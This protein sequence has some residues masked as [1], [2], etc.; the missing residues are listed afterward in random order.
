M[1]H[2]ILRNIGIPARLGLFTAFLALALGVVLWVGWTG[3]ARLSAAIEAEGGN[4]SLVISCAMIERQVYQSWIA[5]KEA[6]TIYVESPDGVSDILMDYENALNTC[7]ALIQMLS[8]AEETPEE[9]A[10]LLE[11]T[12]T[13]FTAFADASGKM[14]EGLR[15]GD[16]QASSSLVAVLSYKALVGEVNKLFTRINKASGALVSESS[17]TAISARDFLTI[18]AA[19]LILISAAFSLLM[20]ASINKPLRSLVSA[21]ERIGRGDL[22]VVADHRGKDELARIAVSVNALAGDLRALVATVEEKLR[23]LADTGGT[24]AAN[25]EETGAAVVQINASIVNSRR[26]LDGQSSAVA[27]VTDSIKGFTLGFDKL[28][29]RIQ[30]LSANVSQSSASTEEMI[31]NIESVAANVEGAARGADLLSSKGVEGKE[32]IDEANEAVDSILRYSEN[33]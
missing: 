30:H 18:I 23:S 20:I 28:S 16:F 1:R 27:E 14:A 19:V 8:Q 10:G 7:R 13:S 24:L 32:R 25:M 4:S 31:A 9:Y 15:S 5:L 22:T 29:D 2:G 12:H 33:L 6:E 3:F 11:T 26:Q 21:V 17:A